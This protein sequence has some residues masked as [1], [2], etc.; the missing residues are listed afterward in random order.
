MGNGDG[1]G[2]KSGQWL[3]GSS[4]RYFDS[5]HSSDVTDPETGEV[6]SHVGLEGF[7]FSQLIKDL[8]NGTYKVGAFVRTPAEGAYIFAS[9]SQDT[10]FVEIP[11][12]YYNDEDTGEQAIASDKFGPIWEAAK[13]QV[14]VLG[15]YT[16]EEYAIFNANSGQGR[17]WKHLD[18]PSIEA[19]ERLLQEYE[20]TLVFTSHDASFVEHVAT[21]KLYIKDG[22]IYVEAP[23]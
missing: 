23:W 20:G 9:A 10:T 6:T 12:D 1:N 15:D 7:S 4:T 8:P 22:L 11:L 18:I 14:E 17:G 21:Q 19:L 3:D 13:Q 5:Y 16:D 2:Q